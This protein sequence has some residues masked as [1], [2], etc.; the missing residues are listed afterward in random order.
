VESPNQRPSSRSFARLSTTRSPARYSSLLFA[1]SLTLRP[2]TPQPLTPNPGELH[3][4]A[5]PPLQARS[6]P[7][8]PTISRASS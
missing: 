8:A 6:T 3:P 5:E 1:S 4:A 2:R 7:T